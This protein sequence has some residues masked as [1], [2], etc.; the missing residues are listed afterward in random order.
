MKIK[1]A[2]VGYGFSAKTF[3]IPFITTSDVFVLHALSSSQSDAVSQDSPQVQHFHTAD[4]M[5]RNSG[6]ELIIITAPNDVHYALA[7]LAL[8]NNKHVLIEKP[9]VTRSKDGAVLIELAKEKGLLLSV[10]QNRRYD[11]DFLTVKKLIDEKRL[12]NVRVYESHFDRFRP[13]VQQRW[14]EQTSDG[15]G[16]LYDLAPHLLDQALSLFG[17]PQSLSARC[18]SMREQASTTDYFH[19][20]LHYQKLEVILHASLFCAGPNLRFQV[21]GDKGSYVKQGLDPQEDCLR[22][23]ELP[24]KPNWGA[25]KSEDFGKFYDGKKVEVITSEK[26][27]YP[28]FF[29]DLAQAIVTGDYTQMSAKQSLNTIKLIELALESQAT[30]KRLEVN[31]EC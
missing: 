23:G 30:G 7:K 21:Q 26:G 22:A 31:F 11:G 9:F 5:I 15:G 29:I 19:L 24:T 17:L 28:D 25:E 27:C 8:E 2:I 12:G 1:T 3:H 18:Q 13:Q 6:A 14:R 4:E 20:V 10:Y 16:I